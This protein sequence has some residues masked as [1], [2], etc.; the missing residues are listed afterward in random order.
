MK[1][2]LQQQKLDRKYKERIIQFGEGNFLRAFVDWIVDD[3]N[4]KLD[5][6]TSAVLVQPIETG[7]VDKINEQ[8]GL[9]TLVLR[10]MKNGQ[11][12]EDAKVIKSVSRGLSPYADYEGFLSLADNPDMRFIVSN[13]TEA[14]IAFNDD[15]KFENTPAKTYPG[16]LTQLLYRRFKT[17]AGDT[18][19][20]FIIM[21][22]ELIDRNGDILKKTVVQYTEKW[23]LGQSF[24]T[25][26]LEANVFCNTLV[27]R[28]VPGYP[29]PTA[30]AIEAK[31][32][33]ED[34]LIVEAEHFHLWVIEGPQWIKAEWPAEEAGLNVLFVDD[35]TP[36]RTRK[37]RILNGAHTVMTPVAFLA[38]ID[39]V[40]EAV[41]DPKMG[42]FIEDALM[43][44]IIPT[45][46]L[47][48]E[49]L[50]SFAQEVKERFRNPFV[51]HALMSISLNSVSKYK[52]RVLPSVQQ[53]HK[54][55]HTLPSNLVYSLAALFAFYR[56]KRG[57]ETI[58][59]NDDKEI[60]D[61]FAQVWTNYANGEL[62]IEAL[63]QKV[64]SMVSFW[65][66]DLNAID[67]MA[68]KVSAY[69]SDILEN[70]IVVR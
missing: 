40:R 11:A 36:Y 58:A 24:R 70:S 17:F 22:C 43:N 57:E 52:A 64:L 68:G 59:V 53:Y 63:V 34:S 66:E 14:G 5:F 15:D 32:G 29:A 16:K 67:G 7:M 50:L 28:I 38:G 21:P 45:L 62:S 69:L 9:Y 1:L 42:K 54:I 19:K 55:Y 2:S 60:M 56:G 3:M 12:C 10:G 23:G 61:L 18:Q 6:N 37:V 48:K 44:E 31:Q 33:Y 47:P 30:K 41:E 4:D 25:W 49:E 26:V 51:R 20:G 65:G 46:D 13:T 8:N 27:D 39:T 35:M